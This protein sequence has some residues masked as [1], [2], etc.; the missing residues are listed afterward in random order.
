MYNN[1]REAKKYE[2]TGCIL[3]VSALGPLLRYVMYYGILCLDVPT[4]V[5]V[6]GFADD[7]VIIVVEKYVE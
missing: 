1:D 5:E 2:V 6:V 4:E 7:I 3:Q